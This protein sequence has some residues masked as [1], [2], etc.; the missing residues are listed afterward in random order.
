MPINPTTLKALIDTQ[1]TNETVD[2]AITPAEVGGRMKD[3][4]DY[5][6]ELTPYRFWRAEVKYDSVVNVL[7]DG[8]GFTSPVVSNPSTGNI[9]LTKTGFFT[10]IDTTKIDFISD[11]IYNFGS[12][13]ITKMF[14][15]GTLGEN[16]N[17]KVLLRI[18]D[19]TGSQSST[20]N[21]S[22]IIEIRIYN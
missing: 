5:T 6:T 4:I 9:I 19:M 15:G 10:G 8:I 13:F 22:C 1:I 17:D 12:I 3:A 18:F 20:P 14:Q 11:N 2:F 21:A 7:Y 16:P